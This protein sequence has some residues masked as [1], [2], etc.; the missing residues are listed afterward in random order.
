MSVAPVAGVVVQV[1]ARRR[2]RRKSYNYAAA[3]L[4]S[5][6]AAFLAGAFLAAGFL[7]GVFL[8]AVFLAA[9]ALAGFLP[10]L[11]A[12]SAIN[13]RAWSSATSSGVMSFGRVALIFSHL[14]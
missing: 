14:I 12:F 7:A 10:P 2:G 3:P 8:A 11:A 13:C 9:A 6:F 4:Q 1:L 5:F